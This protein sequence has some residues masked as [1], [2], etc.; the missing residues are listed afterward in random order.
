MKFTIFFILLLSTLLDAVS[1]DDKLQ[2]TLHH[3]RYKHISVGIHVYNLSTQTEVYGYQKEKKL[4]PASIIKLFTAS[5]ALETFG[6]DFRFETPIY[7]KGEI[8]NNTLNGNL[9]IKGVGDPSLK[10]FHLDKTLKSIIKKEKLYVANGNLIYDISQF[11][12]PVPKNEPN[13]R[14]YYTPSGALNYNRNQIELDLQI[15]THPTIPSKIRVKSPRTDYAKLNTDLIYSKST[16]K[17]GR[18]RMTYKRYKWGDLYTLTGTVSPADKVVDYLKLSVSRPGLL[19]ATVFKE[20]A[21]D[22]GLHIKGKVK[23]GKIP[24]NAIQVGSIKGNSLER[25]TK[26]L[27]E[28]S[29]NMMVEALGKSIVHTR[30]KKTQITA[31]DAIDALNLY[32]KTTYKLKTS[33]LRDL[34]GLSRK[35]KLNAETFTQFFSQVYQNKKDFKALIKVLPVQ[36]ESHYYTT[37]DS[38]DNLKIYIKSGTLSST[39]VNSVLAIIHDTKANHYYVAT[40]IANRIAGSKKTYRGTLTTP[41]LKTIATFLNG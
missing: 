22:H 12:T 20:R 37:K 18:P 35:N 9:Y 28:E 2:E 7:K 29:N 19:T 17:P 32:L 24:K 6:K 27:L 5:H 31:Q 33:P 39:G 13:A 40:I 21:L 8:K 25:I 23:K 26:T 38:Y 36:G 4:I 3:K 10:Q 34:S 14:H 1:L 16:K 11:R 30:T 41:L 15:G